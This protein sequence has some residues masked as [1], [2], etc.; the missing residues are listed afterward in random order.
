MPPFTASE[1]LLLA[2]LCWMA[3]WLLILAQQRRIRRFA[4][5][6]LVLG[7]V[8]AAVSGA[9]WWW[10]H[11]SIALAVSDTPL[12]SSPHGKATMIRTLPSGSAVVVEREQ[13]GW[14]L[15]R[16]AGK[17]LG[18]LPRTAIAPAGE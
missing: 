3:G 18:W 4:P 14:V 16:A 9:T 1:A 12:R 11:R 7:V 5:V 2:G 10:D 8:L 6:A 13:Q 15:V 17:E